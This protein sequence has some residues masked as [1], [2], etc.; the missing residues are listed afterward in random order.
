[1]APVYVYPAALIVKL[2]DR[3]FGSTLLHNDVVVVAVQINRGA[4][5]VIIEVDENLS[6]IE[7]DTDVGTELAGSRFNLESPQFVSRLE[8]HIASRC[9]TVGLYWLVEESRQRRPKSG[10]ALRVKVDRT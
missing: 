7:V 3:V 10:V 5:C 8:R 6:L 9:E 4:P 1:M 2:A